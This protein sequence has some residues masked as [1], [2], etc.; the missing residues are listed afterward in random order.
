VT[1]VFTLVQHSR[2]TSLFYLLKEFLGNQ[3]FIIKEGNKDVVRFR[4]EKLSFIVEVLIPLFKNNLQS[5][6]LEDYLSFCSACY[7]IRDKA[8]LTEEGLIKIKNIK[9][10][11]NT[12][13]K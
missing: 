11:M 9:S 1:P 8:H 2:D 4:A 13:R 12:K 7:L 10:N 6:K 5:K 3:G